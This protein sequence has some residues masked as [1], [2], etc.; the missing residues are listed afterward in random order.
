MTFRAF[1]TLESIASRFRVGSE[2]HGPVPVDP[3]GSAAYAD[4]FKAALRMVDAMV[5]QSERIA[6][7]SSNQSRH[8]YRHR[9]RYLQTRLRWEL[10]KAHA[11]LVE[12]WRTLRNGGAS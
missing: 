6:E 10:E 11:D 5:A 9:L 1:Q 2:G 4:G 7:E 8:A 12:H 3:Y